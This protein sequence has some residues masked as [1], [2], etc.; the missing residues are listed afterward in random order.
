MHHSTAI[1]PSLL[2]LINTIYDN[3]W[4]TVSNWNQASQWTIS[5]TK[6][7][8]QINLLIRVHNLCWRS[9][10]RHWHWVSWHLVR[11]VQIVLQRRVYNIILSSTIRHCKVG[12]S[13]L[14]KVGSRV[15]CWCTVSFRHLN[16]C[17]ITINRW[18]FNRISVIRL[19]RFWR[20]NGWLN[21]ILWRCP[22]GWSS[23]CV[24]VRHL[25]WLWLCQQR[26]NNIVFRLR[27]WLR[28]NRFLCFSKYC[29][30][31]WIIPSNQSLQSWV[32]NRNRLTVIANATYD[33]T[34]RNSTLT[35]SVNRVVSSRYRCL[36]AISCNIVCGWVHHH[37]VS[38]RQLICQSRLGCSRISLINN[39]T[40]YNLLWLRR[41]RHVN[42][43]I[44][45]NAWCHISVTR[46]RQST[47][48]WTCK[49]G[50]VSFRILNRVFTTTVN[51]HRWRNVNDI[52]W[53]IWLVTQITVSAL[54]CF[55]LIDYVT[56]W[57]L[58]RVS[59][60]WVN[61]VLEC[62]IVNGWLVFVH[63]WRLR[64]I[65][66]ITFCQT[67]SFNTKL[68]LV[69]VVYV[70]F[71]RS[72]VVFNGIV[73]IVLIPTKLTPCWLDVIQ[74]PSFELWFGRNLTSSDI[75]SICLVKGVSFRVLL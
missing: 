67:T 23:C 40:R 46:K 11:N 66:D 1:K 20:S 32:I 22:T 54:N 8:V 36:C 30:A 73:V 14:C 33:I 68:N 69:G 51:K 4:Y 21:G 37:R 59:N 74:V 71:L 60:R 18:H 25:Q 5:V 62:H 24:A 50:N 35:C 61:L 63:N 27:I 41:K 34:C 45:Q 39:I 70:E 10:L 43:G 2:S 12:R 52:W 9:R 16:W 28:Q 72:F 57:I 13:Q 26:V 17:L 75:N 56:L 49:A 65:N 19:H 42:V 15:R 48:V 3:S 64:C 58:V 55:A 7:L 6:L 29:R 53:V 38:T 47:R 44:W 31:G